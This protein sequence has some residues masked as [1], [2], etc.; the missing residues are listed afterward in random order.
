MFRKMEFGKKSNIISIITN[1]DNE[2]LFDCFN[3]CLMGDDKIRGGD[4]NLWVGIELTWNESVLRHLKVK[5]FEVCMKKA[6]EIEFGAFRGTTKILRSVFILFTPQN[7]SWMPLNP[8]SYPEFNHFHSISLST[9]I[10][11]NNKKNSITPKKHKTQSHSSHC[12]S[13]PV[14]IFHIYVCCTSKNDTTTKKN[15]SK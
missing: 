4:K 15:D 1:S 5:Y 7:V 14:F 8:D 10:I 2:N 9:L 6:L 3:V 11:L 13:F 12:V